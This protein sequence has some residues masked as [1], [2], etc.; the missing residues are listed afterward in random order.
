MPKRALLFIGGI[1]IIL[2][3][4]I[5]LGIMFKPQPINIDLNLTPASDIK[6]AISRMYVVQDAILCAPGTGIEPLSEILVDTWD[7]APSFEQLRAIV[8]YFGAQ[9]LAHAGYLT[10]QRAYYQSRLFPPQ[11]TPP[12]GLNTTAQPS[13]YCPDP[14]VT[15][16]LPLV[17]ISLETENKA[18]A[19]Y[20]YYGSTYE[21]VLREIDG[22]WMV[23]GV[24]MI[25]WGGNG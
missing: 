17:S 23:A 6:A 25:Y 12:P 5:L 15:P 10:T 11:V 8:N 21:A 2:M 22:K 18:I 13:I 1:A 9:G 16:A 7:Y 19:Q 24:K 20:S 3:A 4:G 14:P